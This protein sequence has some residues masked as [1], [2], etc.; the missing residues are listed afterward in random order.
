MDRGGGERG[1]CVGVLEE[2]GG[3]GGGFEWVG[4]FGG[5]FRFF[6]FSR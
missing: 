4:E 1:E 6:F 2:A 5:V 3:V